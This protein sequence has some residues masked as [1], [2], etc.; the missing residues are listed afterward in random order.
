MFYFNTNK[1]KINFSLAKYWLYQ[2][3]KGPLRGGGECAPPIPPLH[4][5][6]KV[7]LFPVSSQLTQQPKTSLNHQN[8]HWQTEIHEQ[9]ASWLLQKMRLSCYWESKTCDTALIHLGIY[10]KWRNTRNR[11][12]KT[13]N[14][15]IATSR[16]NFVNPLKYQACI[17]KLFQSTH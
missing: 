14:L 10:I 8:H 17:F 6:L 5:S 11:R 7:V 12:V 1:P 9:D 2:K 13:W 15:T 16:F 4:P 3:A